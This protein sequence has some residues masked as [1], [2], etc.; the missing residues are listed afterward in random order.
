MTKA[1]IEQLIA[2]DAPTKKRRRYAVND[3][4]IRTIVQDYRQ[5]PLNDYLRGIAYHILLKR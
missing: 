5:R 2:G 3:N 1:R 4:S